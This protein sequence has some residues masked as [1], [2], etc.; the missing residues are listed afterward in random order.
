[1]QP[2]CDPWI[3]LAAIAVRTTRVCLE[4]LVTPLAQRRPWKLARETVTF[5]QLSHGCLTLGIG[6]EDMMDK[7]FSSVEEAADA[8]VQ[9]QLVDEGL[10]GLWRGSPLAYHGHH[11][12]IEDLTF[13]PPPVQSPCLPIW[14]GGY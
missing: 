11:Y 9:V 3:A 14:I 2:V 1:V 6:L 4:T 10:T 8:K 7:G 13:L 5:D 12:Q